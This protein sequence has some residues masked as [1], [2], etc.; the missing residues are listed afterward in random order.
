MWVKLYSSNRV[1]LN[2]MTIWQID[3]SINNMWWMHKQGRTT[4]KVISGF[5]V[6]YPKRWMKIVIDQ[7]ERTVESIPAALTW[8]MWEE[9]VGVDFIFWFPWSLR[10]FVSFCIYSY[11]RFNWFMFSAL[12]E[13]E[14]VADTYETKV[15]CKEFSIF[16]LLTVLFLV[17]V[18]L[19][20]ARKLIYR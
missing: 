20:S 19:I 13:L 18:N 9:E 12:E 4:N 5:S 8:E 11:E 7:E 10:R 2:F 16:P 15:A 14:D 3:K 17:F 1:N 6:R